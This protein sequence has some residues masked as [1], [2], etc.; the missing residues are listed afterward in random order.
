MYMLICHYDFFF[1]FFF[2]FAFAR[3]LLWHKFVSPIPL[4][5]PDQGGLGRMCL[6][7]AESEPS[8]RQ[9]TNYCRYDQRM[10]F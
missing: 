4:T 6:S 8:P 5:D 7:D 10:L 9:G 2:F 3:A 1:F